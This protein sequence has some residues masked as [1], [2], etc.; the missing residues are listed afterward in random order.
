MV[1]WMVILS[2]GD[3]QPLAAFDHGLL[4]SAAAA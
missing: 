3:F 4:A 1:D 2:D